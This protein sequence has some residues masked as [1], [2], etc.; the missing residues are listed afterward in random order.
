MIADCFKYILNAY[1]DEKSNDFKSSEFA[2]RLSERIPNELSKII[3][4]NNYSVKTFFGQ[5]VWA[6]C[7]TVTLTHKMFKSAQEALVMEFLFDAENESV[8]LSLIPRL[9]NVED[10]RSLKEKL[11]LYLDSLDTGSF[12]RSNDSYSILFKRYARNELTEDTIKKDLKRLTEIHDSLKGVFLNYLFE[13]D[14]I[15]FEN[16]VF[17]CRGEF[18]SDEALTDLEDADA[19]MDYDVI[20]ELSIIPEPVRITAIEVEYPRKMRYANSIT[21]PDELFTDE[22]IEII[23]RC[24][25]SPDDYMVILTDIKKSS[26]KLIKELTETY[27]IDINSLKT[28]DKVLLFSKSFVKTGYKSVGRRLGSYAFNEILVDDRLSNP[29]IITSIIHELS[30]F[31]LE[32]ILKEIL[33]T[34]L[35]TDDTPLISSYIK[36]MMEDNDLN[37][38]LDEFCAH[39]VEGRFALYGFQDYSSFKYK[40][41]E[42]S[43][44]YSQDDI[45]YAL[46]IANTFAYDIKDIFEGF[47]DEDLREDIKDE[48]L[49]IRDNP[50]YSEL[51]FEIE[52]RLDENHFSEA[53]SILLLSGIGE[54]LARPDKLERYMAKYNILLKQ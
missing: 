32:K 44:A 14:G 15:V 47:I 22:T 4:D 46:I 5:Y 29:L 8:T 1:A 35:K 31:M 42:I 17:Y 20:E 28:R 13:I 30:H 24:D 23:A 26:Q 39:C 52:E 10:Y 6:D 7:P 45:D 3:A 51:D 36:I 54:C 9:K 48:F 50:N 37:Y 33:M 27:E 53:I 38:L 16:K 34:I 12:M 41:N 11:N 25:F 49:S 18:S 43:D 40:L 21:S 2:R 19:N